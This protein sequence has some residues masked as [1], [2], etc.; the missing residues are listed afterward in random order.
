MVPVPRHVIIQVV[1]P[2][3]HLR[4]IVPVRQIVQLVPCRH[5]MVVIT[6]V[7]IHALN[8]L[9]VN[10]QRTIIHQ[11]HVRHVLDCQPVPNGPVRGMGAI[12]VRGSARRDITKMAAV[13]RHV[14]YRLPT[15]VL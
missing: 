9:T 6:K 10:I 5:V 1:R 8:V 3:Q 12:L 11:H 13:V 4:Q 15:L 14:M 7:A 2:D